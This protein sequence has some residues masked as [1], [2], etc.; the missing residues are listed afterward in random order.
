MN[1]SIEELELTVRSY[2]CLK[3]ARIKTLGELVSKTE[4]EMLKTRNFGRKSLTE[5]RHILFSMGLSFGMNLSDLDLVAEGI[6]KN[7]EDS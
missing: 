4:S 6:E 7:K 1:G 3:A 5:I 2:N